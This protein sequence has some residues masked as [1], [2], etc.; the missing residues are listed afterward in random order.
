[1]FKTLM[2]MADE[3]VRQLQ[4]SHLRLLK[5]VAPE[6]EQPGRAGAPSTPAPLKRLNAYH[7]LASNL[8]ARQARM[9][10]DW[11]TLACNPV[12]DGSL[13]VEM[14]QM[15]QAVFQRLAAQQAETVQGLAAI[16]V[17]AGHVRKANTLSKLM[18]DEYDLAAQFNAL[19]V[20]QFTAWVE[21][22]ENVQVNA[23]YLLTRKVED[24]KG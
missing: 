21:L 5:T 20:A 13:L 10:Q 9:V 22:A 7:T 23:G 16:A 3:S 14:L 19:L 12:A 1:M 24:A 4:H 11:W 17:G 6:P 2:T 15:Q 18:E 8:A